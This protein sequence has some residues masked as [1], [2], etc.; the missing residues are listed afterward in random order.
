MSQTGQYRKDR[1]RR[2]G[3]GKS[4]GTILAFNPTDEECDV[5][6]RAPWSE[7][8]ALQH[9]FPNE[10]LSIVARRLSP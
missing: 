5:W 10:A 9:S 1:T 4:S 2:C 8:K 7:A 6:M 3:V